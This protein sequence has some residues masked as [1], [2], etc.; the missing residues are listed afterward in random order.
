MMTQDVTTICADQLTD[1]DIIRHSTGDTW[2]VM[3]EPEYTTRGIRFEVLSMFV[4][5]PNTQIV[6]FAPQE[7]FVLLDHQRTSSERSCL[8]FRVACE[9]AIAS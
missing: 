4:E 9:D 1:G 8:N 3:T 2:L 5:A 6:C 7:S